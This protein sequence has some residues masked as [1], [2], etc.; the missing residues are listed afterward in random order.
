MDI[1]KEIYKHWSGRTQNLQEASL[2]GSAVLIPLIQN[3]DFYDVL[4]E[5]RA[6]AL[7]AQP[8]EVCFPGGQMEK[9]ETPEQTAVRE[10]TE[11][12]LVR[13]DQIKILA[14]IDGMVGPGGRPIW[15]FVGLLTGYTDT[16]LPDEVDHVFRVP[17]R[18]FIN[19]S[20]ENYRTVRKTVPAPGFPYERIPGGKEYPWKS[21]NYDV[22][23]Y[24]W[25]DENIWGITARI[26]NEMVRECRKLLRGN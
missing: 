4:F 11:E 15:P 21:Q 20:P 18:W 9:C 22:P 19:H 8:G 25:P 6:R 26:M 5:V 2:A 12:L 24:D 7:D 10:T 17:L 1:A 13:R 16:S 14:P 23:F 3:G